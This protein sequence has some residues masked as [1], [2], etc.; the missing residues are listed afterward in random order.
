[1]DAVGYNN[2]E[3]VKVLLAKGADQSI[4]N[5]VSFLNFQFIVSV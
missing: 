4:K 5:N 2:I 1:M 3:A